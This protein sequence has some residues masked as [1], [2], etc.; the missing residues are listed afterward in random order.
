MLK[1]FIKNRISKSQKDFLLKTF[2]KI[3][4]R[5]YKL[6]TV[7][8][9]HNLTKLAQFYGTD[10][11]GS[12]FYAQHYSQHFKSIRKNKIRLLE[13]GVGGYENTLAGGESLRMWKKYFPSGQIFGID[14]F[15]KSVLEEKRIKMFRG[16]QIDENFLNYVIDHTDNLDIIIDDG[17]HINQH[18]I[19]S[20]K[21]LFPKLK[22]GGFYIIEDTQTSYW[23]DYG[24]DSTNLNNP[25][26]S[27]NYFKSLVDCINHEERIKP[28]Y[29]PSFFDKNIVSI[30]F[31]HNII[32]IQ[33]G[34]N[35]EGSN[36]VKNNCFIE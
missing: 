24:G 35:N 27:L 13:I 31:Y 12:H 34:I 10:K 18:I 25:A 29:K 11:W 20:F 17:S 15:D 8:F 3:K 5:F 28:G 16:S 21:V 6:S 26:T 2:F 32:F 7:L 9:S 4:K 36:M 30:H 23:S 33:K 19:A 22:Q 14:I 1:E